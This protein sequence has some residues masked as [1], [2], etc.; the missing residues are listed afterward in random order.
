M[1]AGIDQDLGGVAFATLEAAAAATP[2]LFDLAALDRAAASVLRTKFAAGLFDHATV[3]PAGLAQ[4]HSKAHVALAREAAAQA[5]VLLQNPSGHLPLSLAAT[6]SVALLGPNSGCFNGSTLCDVSRNMCGSY[7]PVV[8]AGQ[9][10]TV[11]DALAAQAGLTVRHLQGVAIDSDDTSGVAAAAAASAASDATIVVLG[12]NLNTCGESRDRM[13]LGLPGMQLE[14]LYAVLEA[15]KK[16]AGGPKPVVAVL[17]NCRAATFGEGRHSKFGPYNAML[18]DPNLSVLAAWI[19]GEQGGP[20]VVDALFGRA[21]PSGR[22]A[23]PFPKAAGYIHSWTTPWFHLRQE[24]YDWNGKPWPLVDGLT[25]D[26]IY[27]FGHGLSYNTINITGLSAAYNKAAQ[28]FD[29]SVDVAVHGSYTGAPTAATVQVYFQQTTASLQVRN[30]LNLAGFAKVWV[31]GP[32]AKTTAVVS[33]RVEDL[34]Y[35]VW[36]GITGSHEYITQPG[37]YTLHACRSSCDCVLSKTVSLP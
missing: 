16:R 20:P 13:E 25:Y 31:G 29:V 9:V 8:K 12:D 18:A 19:G 6:R 37:E 3:D 1:T 30:S 26:P 2:P 33:V 5:L 21:Q 32:G 7:S 23:Q 4:V 14:L 22:L 27:C 11:A 24:D 15:N 17:I 34:G 35:T 10:A 36:D 28:R